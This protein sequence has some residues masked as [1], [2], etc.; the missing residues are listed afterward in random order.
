T[1][2]RTRRGSA[3]INGWTSRHKTEVSGP[4]VSLHLTE[5]SKTAS[6]I[7]DA[8]GNRLIAKNADG[9]STLTLPDENELT[10]RA[11][12]TIMRLQPSSRVVVEHGS[13]ALDRGR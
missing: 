5:N 6:Y 12:N 7:Y 11:R 13:V 3:A 8:D 9:T 4:E 2:R 10:L 1:S